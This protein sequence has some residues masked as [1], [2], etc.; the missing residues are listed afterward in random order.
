MIGLCPVFGWERVSLV[1][2]EN[3][4][5]R[6]FTGTVHRTYLPSETDHH[7]R[8]TF[9]SWTL[10]PRHSGYRLHCVKGRDIHLMAMHV[11]SAGSAAAVAT[12][13]AAST[14]STLAGKAS[15]S[16]S[17]LAS[18]ILL[19]ISNLRLLNLDKRADWPDIDA[20]VFD[21]KDALH[22]QKR[23]IAAVEWAL[24]RLFE[25]W[26]PDLTRNVS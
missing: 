3:G 1:P 20:Q 9:I 13:A 8:A 18:H 17:T 6:L 26:D 10:T 2:A 5:S 24:Y 11:S 21:I 25:M 22:N 4:T 19:F 16:K 12:A 23:R 15:K 7:R 14:S